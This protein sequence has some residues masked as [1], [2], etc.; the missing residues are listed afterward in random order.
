MGTQEGIH[1]RCAHGKQLASA[2]LDEV[3]TLMPF[4]GVDQGGQPPSI[5][6][7]LARDLGKGVQQHTFLDR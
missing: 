4:Q 5:A 2:L 7:M 1:C 6:A 3:E